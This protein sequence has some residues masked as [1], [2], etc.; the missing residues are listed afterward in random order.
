MITA[1][2]SFEEF[3]HLMNVDRGRKLGFVGTWIE[4]A[5]F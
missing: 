3:A 5:S 1:K 4:M 2:L